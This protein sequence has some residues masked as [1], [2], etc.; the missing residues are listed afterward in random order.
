MN[1]FKGRW[2]IFTSEVEKN[3]KKSPD[4]TVKHWWEKS[5]QM[6]LL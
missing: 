5:T 3:K 4:L 6:F 1:N 2:A